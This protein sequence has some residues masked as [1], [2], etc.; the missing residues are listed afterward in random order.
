MSLGSRIVGGLAGLPPAHTSRVLVER[1]LR[2]PMLDGVELLADR[3]FPRGSNQL[4]IVL[5][6][7]PYGRRLQ[8]GAIGRLFAERGY[9]SVVQS[10][11][12]TFGSG[13]E[14]D[15]FRH[16]GSDG[17]TTLEWLAK[18]SWFGGSVGMFGPSYL[19][20]VQ[21]AA[22]FNGPPFLKALVPCIAAS[23]FRSAIYSGEA[24]S[25]DTVLTMVDFVHHQELSFWQR[26]QA[27]RTHGRR[28]ARAFAH[29]PLTDVDRLATGRP[30]KFFQDWLQ[31]NEPGDAY[32]KSVDFSGKV[33]AAPVSLVAGWYD[34]F[35]PGQLADYAALRKAGLPCRLTVGPWTH[36]SLGGARVMVNE[37][38]AWFNAYLRDK[39]DQRSLPAV[40]VFVMGSKR[41][42]D[43]AEW[44]PRTI[45]G[46][47]HLQPSAG[48][49]RQV[50]GES[51]PDEFTYDPR[52]PTPSVGGIV[53][54][55][56]AGPKDNRK[57]EA[58]PDV[59]TY[60]TEPLAHDLEVIGPLVAELYIRSSL[61]HTDFF[62]RVCDV[63][64]D[65]RSTNVCDGL[66]RLWPGRFPRE[67]DGG[68]C[69]KVELWPTAYSFRRGHRIRMQVSSGAH[70]R[71]S[72]NLGTGEPL[73]SAVSLES[74]QQKI[75]H[76]PAHA[77]ALLLPE[78]S[79]A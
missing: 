20:F 17:R 36:V 22:A 21:W 52:H 29:L 56:H 6:R 79:A 58:R 62:V 64:P 3:Y 7:S 46:R 69:I 45:L 5:M 2:I 75:F 8:W 12:G 13:G 1:D 35:L 19:G 57:L 48:L 27:L 59:L 38:L 42:L 72:R 73:G 23:Q 53:Q 66:V 32:W 50:P 61:D 68:L 39:P 26:L 24:F 77:S 51:F 70:P 25:L 49:A 55:S 40:R 60:T 78:R 47:W 9:Q 16:E 37:G 54:G 41:W 14:F 74:A 65:G 67:A 63:E 31:H 43:L 33:P 76:D 28:L 34:V 11:R 30:I 10:T 4:P 44:P 71:Y 18:Q 15:P